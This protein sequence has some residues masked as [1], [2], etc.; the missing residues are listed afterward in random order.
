MSRLQRARSLLPPGH[1][2][3]V[4]LSPNPAWEREWKGGEGKEG[5]DDGDESDEGD[6][7]NDDEGSVPPPPSAGGRKKG[8]NS[9]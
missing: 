2:A 3:T 6:D 4:S 9:E 5:N 8:K 1:P 7:D